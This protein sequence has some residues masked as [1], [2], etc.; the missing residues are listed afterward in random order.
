MSL[1]EGL[2][3]PQLIAVQPRTFCLRVTEKLQKPEAA[4]P[5]L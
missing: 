1:G 2:L 5:H 3:K 4:T